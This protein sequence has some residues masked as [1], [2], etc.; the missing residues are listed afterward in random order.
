MK[1]KMKDQLTNESWSRWASA[2][3]YE[4]LRYLTVLTVLAALPVATAGPLHGQTPAPTLTPADA[5]KVDSTGSSQGTADP[6]KTPDDD[7]TPKSKRG[8]WL[9]APIPINSPAF[10]AGLVLVVGYVFRFSE[11]DKLSPPSTVGA[12]A[13]FTN[14][15]S[16]GI[17]AGGKLY[18]MENKYQTTLAF[19]T[20]R[21]NYEY[22]GTGRIP[23]TSGRSVEIRQKGGF[24]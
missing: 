14:N 15:G 21:A 9:L 6:Q 1:T 13:A 12:I 23:G 10:G 5:P 17:V 20:G 19:G 4:T 16:R 3:V 2:V 7:S 18:F 22:F 8:S 24:L 11:S